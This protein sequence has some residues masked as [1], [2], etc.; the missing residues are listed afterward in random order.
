MT[1]RWILNVLSWVLSL[2]LPH[3][4]LLCD[5]EETRSAY[6]RRNASL[7]EGY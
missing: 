7:L 2:W 1:E 6:E 4:K 3:P 5:T